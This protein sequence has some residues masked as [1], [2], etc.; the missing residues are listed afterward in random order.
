MNNS[1]FDEFRKTLI[2]LGELHE[3]KITQAMG[4]MYWNALIG[5]SIEDFR[6]SVDCHNRDPDQG[7]FFPKPANLMKHVSGTS[8]Q[9]SQLIQDRS[10]IAWSVVLGEISRIGSYATLKLDDKVSMAAVKAIGG[11][12]HICSLTNDQLVWAAKEFQ[13]TY[14]QYDRIDVA[15]LP[16]KLPGRI[17]LDQNKIENKQ[18]MKTLLDGLEN[19]NSRNKK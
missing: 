1:D 7:M 15:L 19:F 12:K 6:K 8:K 5:L 17:E 18:G 4:K 9:Q 11:W 13:S 2:E 10:S 16:D 3:K 14:E